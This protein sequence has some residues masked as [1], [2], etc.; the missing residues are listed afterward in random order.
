M[1]RS[2]NSRFVP[3]YQRAGVFVAMVC[4]LVLIAQAVRADGDEAAAMLQQARDII[5]DAQQ[6]TL[7]SGIDEAMPV[8]LGGTRQWI[9]VRG[10]DRD[11]PI[12]LFVHGGPAFPESPVSWFY[13]RPWEDYFTVVQ[14][15]QRASGKSVA[16][17]DMETVAPTISIE[18]MVQ[19]GE[20]LVAFLRQRYGKSKIFVLGH[21]WGSVI[22]LEIARRHPEWLY[23]YVGMGQ[24]INAREN[25]RLGYEF[26]LQA[27]IDDKNDT[28][29]ADLQS[30]APYPAP[31]GSL[32]V[33]H[34]L[35]QRKWLIHYGGMTWGRENLAYE[36]RLGLLS[37]DYTKTDTAVEQATNI[38]LQK[39]LPELASM[40][41]SHVERIDCPVV[42]LA[43][44]HDY[45]TV[46]AVAREWI[47]KLQAP[48]KT[49]VLFKDTAHMIQM[50]APGKLLMHLVNDVRLF[51]EEQE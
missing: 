13:Q 41:F 14:W 36:K 1:K 46:T 12:L 28:A 7:P 29:I 5:A 9:S 43:G 19:D 21:S 15:D 34:I 2:G 8:A 37:P 4:S 22:G 33:R 31:D 32:N 45:A 30:I 3:V 17:N 23:A 18:R 38:S 39:L 42:I 10:R 27:A 26:A 49:F 24:A 35:L 16:L 6:L 40:D 51:A 25:E 50:E 20:E 47:E 11:N 48:A 44:E